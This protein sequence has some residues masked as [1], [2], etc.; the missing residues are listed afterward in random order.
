MAG[1]VCYF[2]T[3]G[4]SERNP[5]AMGDWVTVKRN[6]PSAVV[7][8][9]MSTSIRV[10]G[11]F[12]RSGYFYA[13]PTIASGNLWLFGALLKLSWWNFE[14][15]VTNDREQ[16]GKYVDIFHFYIWNSLI[17][18]IY[19]FIEVGAIDGGPSP[20]SRVMG[21]VPECAGEIVIRP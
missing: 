3:T 20:A 9:S 1:L 8:F 6:M 11:C 19:K 5:F 18:C 14:K 17:Y 7:E 2:A 16:F 13:S 10:E 15:F 21:F 12:Y 4:V